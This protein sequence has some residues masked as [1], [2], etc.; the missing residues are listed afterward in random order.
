MP[1]V[2]GQWQDWTRE[3]YAQTDEW[4]RERSQKLA[5]LQEA[6]A[7][8]PAY[9]KN[10]AGKEMLKKF[11]EET[12]RGPSAV[13]LNRLNNEGAGADRGSELDDFED[14]LG[15]TPEVAGPSMA[16]LRRY[17]MASMDAPARGAA[18]QMGAASQRVGGL[19]PAA[20]TQALS[21]I[22]RGGAGMVGGGGSGASGGAMAHQAALT[23]Y[24]GRMQDR[25]TLANSMQQSINQGYAM[26]QIG[27]QHQNAMSMANL[28]YRLNQKLNK[29]KGSFWSGLGT[30]AGTLYGGPIGAAVGKRVGSWIGGQGGGSNYAS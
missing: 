2:D 27:V 30:V 21:E 15:D 28:N 11:N 25:M 1:E 7:A 20:R 24:Q 4:Q 9:V 26:D 14:M 16:M 13:Y 10:K 8:L 5:E 23:T 6:V 22:S 29:R 12:E 3:E 18:I 19:N 17:D